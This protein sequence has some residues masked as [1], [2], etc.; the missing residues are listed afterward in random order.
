MYAVEGFFGNLWSFH[1]RY[2]LCRYLLDDLSECERKSGRDMTFLVW[3]LLVRAASM[4]SHFFSIYSVLYLQR[5]W[6]ALISVWCPVSCRSPSGNFFRERHINYTISLPCWY[7]FVLPDNTDR[8]HVKVNISRLVH[9]N[10]VYN[11]PTDSLRVQDRPHRVSP[12]TW[13]K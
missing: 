5:L 2:L 13:Q 6:L 12:R 3:I 11:I 4:S 7:L 1:Y 8:R 10:I 9:H